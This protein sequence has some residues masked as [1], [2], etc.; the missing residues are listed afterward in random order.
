MAQTGRQVYF[1]QA[2]LALLYGFYA[3]D[4]VKRRDALQDRFRPWADARYGARLEYQLQDGHEYRVQ[5]DFT[6]TDVP[7]TV[8]DLA[9]GKDITDEFGRRRRGNVPFMARQL[10]MPKT[11]FETCAFISQG[12][13]FEIVGEDRASPQEIGDTIVSL[14]DTGRRDLS[15]RLAIERLEKVLKDQVGTKQARTTPL[16]VLGIDC[17]RRS[18]VEKIKAASGSR[19][20]GG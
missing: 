13:L 11:V 16:P 15:A 20:R 18:A 9:V 8:W 10:G 4:N 14:A 3:S 2:V 12:E 19:A 17:G 5:R 1:Q 6:S 7:T